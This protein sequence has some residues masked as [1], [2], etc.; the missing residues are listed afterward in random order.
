[1]RVLLL[2]ATTT[3]ATLY[4]EL[5]ATGLILIPPPLFSMMCIVFW[6]KIYAETTKLSEQ[7]RAFVGANSLEVFLGERVIRQFGL[8]RAVPASCFGR[9]EWEECGVRIDD[10]KS[11]VKQMA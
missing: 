6:D 7:R 4:R 2:D 11:C 10:R 5:E 9:D 1:M 3:D 8:N